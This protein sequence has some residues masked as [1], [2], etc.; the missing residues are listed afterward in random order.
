MFSSPEEPSG[1]VVQ[2]LFPL[3]LVTTGLFFFPNKR[4]NV[5]STLETEISNGRYQKPTVFTK[6]DGTIKA[7]PAWW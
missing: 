3:S 6:G 5:I 1:L 4:M 7:L 2:A